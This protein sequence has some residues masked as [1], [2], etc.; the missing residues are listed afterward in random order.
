MTKKLNNMKKLILLYTLLTL[1]FVG[2]RKDDNPKI[3]ELTRVPVPLVTIDA[4]SDKVINPATPGSFKGKITVDLYFKTDV[5]PKKMDLM[6][7]KNGDKTTVKTL[8]ADITTFPTTV[9]FTG[10]QLI[11]LFG[12][13]ADGDKFDISPDITTQNGQVF[14]AFPALGEGYGT[15]V[16]AQG[17][18][19][20]SVSFL[21]PCTYNPDMYQGDFAVVKDAWNDTNPGDIIKLTKI[22]ATHFSF[23]YPTAV[24]PIPI[25]VTV[26]PSTNTPS[27]ALQTIGT[28]W[29]YDD[30]PPAP[31]AKTTAGAANLVD[32]CNKTLSLNMTWT[33]AAG[34]YPNRVF[35][36]K[37]K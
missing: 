13:I 20:T 2:C 22:D 23:I 26:D 14:Q 8:K 29:V 1:A 7:M 6:V 10:Q 5:P 34:S 36:L 31:T 33:E 18:A 11:S 28:A 15:G 17:G 25:I 30:D 16:N 35:S 4:T 32:P 27:I 3:P 37:K 19:S 21:K 12:P 9:E 24:N